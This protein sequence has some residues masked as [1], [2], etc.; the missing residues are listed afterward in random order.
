MLVKMIHGLLIVVV[1]IIWL[2][3]NQNLKNL[4]HYDGGSVRFGNN[5]PYCV[6]QKGCTILTKE[7]RCDSDYWVEGLKNNILSVVQL[8]KIGFKV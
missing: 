7:L 4:E 5:E 3:I 6:K 8:K 2:L 1:L